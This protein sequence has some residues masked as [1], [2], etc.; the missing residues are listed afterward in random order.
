MTTS[1][2]RLHIG[3]VERREG[4]ELLNMVSSGAVGHIGDTRELSL[5]LNMI[6]KKRFHS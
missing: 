2:R 3:G 5:S 1:I 6:A 4:S